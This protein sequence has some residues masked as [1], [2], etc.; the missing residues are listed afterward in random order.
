MKAQRVPVSTWLSAVILALSLS[1]CRSNKPKEPLLIAGSSTMEMYLNPLVKAFVKKNPGASVVC[2]S[3]GASAGVIALKHEAI[4]IAMLSRDV[5]TE[6]DDTHLKDYLIARD[7]VAIVVNPQNPI[8]T[9][10]TAQLA[11]IASGKATSWR[12]FAC[13]D[14][15]TACAFALP[16]TLVDRPKTSHL[17]KSFM[18]LVLSGE[19]PTA[20]AK[21]LQKSD[22]VIAAVQADVGAIAY[23]SLRRFT[24]ALKAVA[25]N[26]VEMN[27]TTML[28][29]RYPLTRS[30]YLAVYHRPSKLAESFIEFAI[31]KEGQ[32]LLAEDGLLNVY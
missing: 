12:D 18:D 3:G 16:I 25:I 28:S 7:G 26:G 5:N 4:D 10:T 31:G 13:P 24:T 29:G 32:T 11:S 6:E 9:L 19:E 27:R 8:G 22:E 2:D 17:R 14:S 1:S 15:K 21:V 30:F 20:S 23:V